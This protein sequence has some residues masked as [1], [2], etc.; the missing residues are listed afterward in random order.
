MKDDSADELDFER[1]LS[2]HA[3]SRLADGSEGF[4]QYIVKS[5]YSG[6]SRLELV[7]HS[8]K[9]LIAHFLVGRRE[10]FDLIDDRHDLF[11]LS[12]AVCSDYFIK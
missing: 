9:L 1:T 3:V 12:L 4:G 2:E 11:D 6:E 8:P 10:R 5:L 7:G